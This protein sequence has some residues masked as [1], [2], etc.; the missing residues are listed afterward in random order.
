MA[1]TTVFVYVKWAAFLAASGW[2]LVDA[3]RRG[4]G[5]FVPLSAL[6]AGAVAFWLPFLSAFATMQ[7]FSA[8]RASGTLETLLTAPVRESQ[9]V[10]GKFQAAFM[11]GLVG[12]LVALLAPL[13]V[14]PRLAPLLTNTLSACALLA[15]VLVL[16]VQLALWTV[17]GLF[18]S[19]L[20][21]QQA[22]AAACSLF[23]C[24][25]L[26]R[27]LTAAAGAWFPAT[28]LVVLG[29]SGRAWAMDTA[30]GLINFSPFV[31]FGVAIW[32]FLLLSTLLLETRQIRT[33]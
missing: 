32:V 23:F 27:A 17:V 13:L 1:L 33:G 29:L 8:E 28:P 21:E 3:L 24:L 14:L 9:V 7:S 4:E 25:L 26:P 19:L 18:F 5:G 6:W 20:W 11:V 2:S 10:W 30:S 22:A 16:M 12:L 31:G 15:A